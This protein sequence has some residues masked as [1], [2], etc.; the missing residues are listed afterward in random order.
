MQGKAIRGKI[1][2]LFILVG[3]ERKNHFGRRVISSFVLQRS[4]SSTGIIIFMPK[5]W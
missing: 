2:I 5:K 1:L 3:M 4:Y